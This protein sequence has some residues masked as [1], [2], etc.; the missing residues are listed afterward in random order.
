M[1]RVQSGLRRALARTT[2]IPTLPL[3]HADIDSSVADPARRPVSYYDTWQAGTG[4][5]IGRFAAFALVGA[6]GCYSRHC[7]LAWAGV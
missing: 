6:E 2:G 5:Y 3:I 7:S 1:R 4:L